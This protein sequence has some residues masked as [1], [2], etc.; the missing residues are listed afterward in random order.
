MMWCGGVVLRWCGGVG[1]CD[2]EGGVVGWWCCGV[3]LWWCCGVVV[4]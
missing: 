2:G 1:W 3:M 4:V